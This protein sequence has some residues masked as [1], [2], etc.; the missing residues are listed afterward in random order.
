VSVFE[1][2]RNMKRPLTDSMDVQEFQ[3][4]TKK[5]KCDT[6]PTRKRKNPGFDRSVINQTK[7][8]VDPVDSNELK[9][10]I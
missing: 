8:T 9:E 5:M 4:L 1:R 7:K 10:L 6:K 3:K 2:R